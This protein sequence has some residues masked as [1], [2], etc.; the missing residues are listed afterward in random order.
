[1]AAPIR[2]LLVC[3]NHTDYLTKSEKTGLWLSELTHFYD[4]IA[5]RNILI[6]IA[7]P[8]GGPI[9][10]D[11]RSLKRNDT[12]NDKWYH[13]AILKP[14]LDESLPLDSIDPQVYKLIYLAGG[15]GTMW[16]F[17]EN[18]KL[19]DTVRQIYEQGGMIAAVCH[20]VA[21]LLNV[22][23]SDGT[24]LVCDRQITGFSSMEEKLIGLKDEVPFLLE[25]ALK[26][27]SA[28]YSK[29]FLPFLPH[30]EVDERMV[31]GQNPASA[32]KV[33]RKVVEEM[34]DK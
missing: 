33:G 28:L 29:S 18:R 4:E 7:S 3:T 2:A 9:P 20:G 23:L 10:L 32:R 8:A 27:K 34:F 19:Q 5:D 30:I 14:K 21:G 15:H 16:D 6:D 12:T 31:T 24:A 17:P 22:H 1:M 13:S 26:A 11:A 25:D